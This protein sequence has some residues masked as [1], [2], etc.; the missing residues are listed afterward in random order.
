MRRANE[1]REAN[2]GAAADCGIASSRPRAETASGD[3]TKQAAGAFSSQRHQTREEQP[4]RTTH[5]VIETRIGDLTLVAKDGVLSG[6]YFPGHWTRPD[7]ATFGERSEDGFDEANDQLSD[8]LG[9]ERTRFELITSA[10][11]DAFQR[12]V[13]NMIEQIPYGQTSTYGEL[14]R[15]LGSLT[16]ARRVG[17]AVAANPLS[18]IVP[19]HRVIGTAGKLTGYAGG[20]ERKQFLLELEGALERPPDPPLSLFEWVEADRSVEPI[21][22]W[23]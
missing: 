20:L 7:P 21:M 11:G 18:I 17:N 4:M 8:Y 9:G 1:V 23:A 14:A 12:H 22:R 3:L 13:W 10:T 19:C 6:V 5:A 2:A 15:K 16:L